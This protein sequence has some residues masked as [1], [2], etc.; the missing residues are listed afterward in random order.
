MAPTSG[1]QYRTYL[2]LIARWQAWLLT[3]RRLGI[4]IR[5]SSSESKPVT[6]L[7]SRQHAGTSAVPESPFVR[8]WLDV[9]SRM[10]RQPREQR[11]RLRDPDPGHD[12]R[13]QPGRGYDVLAA[14]SRNVRHYRDH[15]R[16]QHGGSQ[17]STHVGD[18]QLV[19]P[20]SRLLRG[21]GP[22]VGPLSEKQRLRRLCS[23][24]QTHPYPSGV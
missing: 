23:R 14:D 24:T 13:A 17:V 12:Q 19:W 5:R 22:V 16:V 20:H 11:L 9:D 3:I 15:H 8:L 21:H 10:D 1:G 4:R 2:N 7:I 6:P 18:H